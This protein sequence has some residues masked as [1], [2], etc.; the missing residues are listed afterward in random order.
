G[1]TL[2]RTAQ[3]Q[4]LA[5]KNQG[6]LIPVQQAINTPGALLFSF[7]S[8]PSPTNMY[9]S[10]AHVAI[11]LGNG[12]TIEARG[13]AYGVGIFD[14]SN[15]FNSAAVLPGLTACPARRPARFDPA[16]GRPIDTLLRRAWMVVR[17][18]LGFRRADRTGTRR[19]R[20]RRPARDVRGVRAAGRRARAQP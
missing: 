2:P 1:V 8:E 3:Q 6:D 13:H 9:P 20:V 17:S 15:R 19:D 7:S 14:A 16:A 11:S 18:C 10:H 4:Y 5:L 12:K